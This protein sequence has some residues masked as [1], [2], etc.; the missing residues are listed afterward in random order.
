[1]SILWLA[2]SLA[3]GGRGIG[4]TRPRHMREICRIDRHLEELQLMPELGI[5]MLCQNERKPQ[6]NQ[7]SDL[8]V[9]VR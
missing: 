9:E 5:V 3:R 8:E 6:R 2:R 4:R 7:T 1:M